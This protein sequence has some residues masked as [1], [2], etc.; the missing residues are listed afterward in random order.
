MTPDLDIDATGLKCP[1]PVLRAQKALRAM[2]PG[3]VLR[4]LASDPVAVIDM[5]HFCAEAGHEFLGVDGSGAVPAFL[6][7]R[8][9]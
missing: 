3:Q 6:I 7:R 4:I 1:L 5:P 2:A 9:T 8:G